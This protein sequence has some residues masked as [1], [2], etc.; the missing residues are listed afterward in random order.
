MRT[1]SSPTHDDQFFILCGKSKR[2]PKQ[3]LFATNEGNFIAYQDTQKRFLY[4]FNVKRFESRGVAA[5]FIEGLLKRPDCPVEGVYARLV[6]AKFV[7]RKP[8]PGERP[9]RSDAVGR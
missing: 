3:V 5:D 4:P 9:K 7:S 1:K 6:T 8:S 2:T